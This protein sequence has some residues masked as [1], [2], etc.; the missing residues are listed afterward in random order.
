MQLRPAPLMCMHVLA[1]A[2]AGLEAALLHLPCAGF[3]IMT[4]NSTSW[5]SDFYTLG[6]TFSQCTITQPVGGTAAPTYHPNC[7]LGQPN[8]CCIEGTNCY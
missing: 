4:V 7:A 3:I 5:R 8:A 1:C 6:S 2:T